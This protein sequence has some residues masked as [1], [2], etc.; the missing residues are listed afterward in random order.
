[1]KLVVALVC[2]SFGC[3]DGGT[4]GL[5]RRTRPHGLVRRGDRS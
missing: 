2:L 4:A 1:M 5:V 3:G